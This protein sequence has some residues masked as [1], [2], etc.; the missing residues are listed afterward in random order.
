[1]SL[2]YLEQVLLSFPRPIST[3]L[4]HDGT[5]FPGGN[6]VN[7]MTEPHDRPFDIIRDRADNARSF[8]QTGDVAGRITKIEVDAYSENC[9][10]A[11]YAHVGRAWNGSIFII[12][13]PQL[14]NKAAM[15]YV[16][17]FFY[18]DFTTH[19]EPV[20]DQRSM[21]GIQWHRA[22]IENIEVLSRE[23]I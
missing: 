13:R 5:E 7:K 12:E 14:A 17:R 22:T 23:F 8:V 1:M 9:V 20:T 19:F 3:L 10:D 6:S 11:I 18:E 2:V 16:V 21:S 4:K 15:R